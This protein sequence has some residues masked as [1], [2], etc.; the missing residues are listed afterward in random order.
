MLRHALL[1]HVPRHV[2]RPN[3][4]SRHRT[5]R[6]RAWHWLLRWHLIRCRRLWDPC[7]RRLPHRFLHA[8]SAPAAVA[9]TSWAKATL[10]GQSRGQRQ[11]PSLR[12]AWQ[13]AA[14]HCTLNLQPPSVRQ[15]EVFGE[16]VAQEIIH[17]A[18]VEKDHEAEPTMIVRRTLVDSAGCAI[19]LEPSLLDPTICAEDL[20]HVILAHV[21]RHA[22]NK[23]LARMPRWWT[24]CGRH[25]GGGT[26]AYCRA[27]GESLAAIIAWP[28]IASTSPAP[29]TPN[30]A[31][32]CAATSTT[33]TWG[34]QGPLAV[35]CWRPRWRSWAGPVVKVWRCPGTR[36]HLTV[37]P[38][39][40]A[41]LPS[42]AIARCAAIAQHVT[43]AVLRSENSR[44]ACQILPRAGRWRRECFYWLRAQ[45]RRLARAPWCRH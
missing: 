35:G 34:L 17:G 32:I 18:T 33:S 15:R 19:R 10:R 16:A 8:A 40:M 13:I 27:G 22:A 1:C 23:N 26:T 5:V 39:G 20:K 28:S 25:P 4:L 6:P 45:C 24:S 36:T 37:R 11:R 7:C 43:E 30:A 38:G 21:L 2:P 29:V 12:L 3:R 44:R 41:I 9:A 42:K 31:Q 14:G